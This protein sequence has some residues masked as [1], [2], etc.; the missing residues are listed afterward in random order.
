MGLAIGIWQAVLIGVLIFGIM[1]L[2]FLIAM[3]KKY[4]KRK[5]QGK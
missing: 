5:N 3:I 1:F 4:Q 2:S